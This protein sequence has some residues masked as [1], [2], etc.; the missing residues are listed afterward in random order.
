MKWIQYVG[1]Y[2]TFTCPRWQ[3][4]ETAARTPFEVA[5]EV[6]ED[7]LSQPANFAPAKA[8][9]TNTPQEG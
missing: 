3:V 6:A 2:D 1:P 9:K 8:P 5:D 7:L 4:P